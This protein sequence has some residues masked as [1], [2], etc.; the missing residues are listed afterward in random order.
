MR[1]GLSLTL[2][3]NTPRKRAQRF[4]PLLKKGHHKRLSQLGA[5]FVFDCESS[6]IC[7]TVNLEAGSGGFDCILNTTGGD[8]FLK[9]YLTC[10]L[11]VV[12]RV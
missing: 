4:L 5:D 11:A 2:P 9:T 7:E 6:A 3:F 12:S 1:K 8:G 10:A